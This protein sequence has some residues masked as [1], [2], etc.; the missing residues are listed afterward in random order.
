MVRERLRR[1]LTSRSPPGVSGQWEETGWCPSHPP[2]ASAQRG[3]GAGGAGVKRRR[4]TWGPPAA[5]SRRAD[6]SKRKGAKARLIRRAFRF[7][8]NRWL[9]MSPAP[10]PFPLQTLLTPPPPRARSRALASYTPADLLAPSTV[11]QFY[12]PRRPKVRRPP[13][14]HTRSFDGFVQLEVAAPTRESF[15]LF[16]TGPALP[17]L[18]ELPPEPWTRPTCLRPAAAEHRRL[19]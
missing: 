14:R 6:V 16:L 4:S 15:L 8:G 2:G 7:H 11:I 3:R 1:S 9:R 19:L 13:R 10:C 18:P 17:E 12:E 5:A